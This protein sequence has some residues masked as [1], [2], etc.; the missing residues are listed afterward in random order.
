MVE[1]VLKV[2]V[3]IVTTA[4]KAVLDLRDDISDVFERVAA[5]GGFGD[6]L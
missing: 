5:E 6:G 4:L 1:I 2:V 3:V